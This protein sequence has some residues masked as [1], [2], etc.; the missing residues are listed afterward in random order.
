MAPKNNERFAQIVG[1][2]FAALG[3]TQLEFKERG[4]PSDTT[5]RKILDG[6]PVGISTRTLAGLDRAFGWT[7]GSAARTLAGGTPAPMSKDAGLFLSKIR[8]PRNSGMVNEAID[9]GDQDLVAAIEEVLETGQASPAALAQFERL[10]DDAN[11]RNFPQTYA[12]L[13]REGQLKVAAYGHQVQREE[14]EQR[15]AARNAAGSDGEGTELLNNAK[16]GASLLDALPIAPE[17]SRN[18]VS[19]AKHGGDVADSQ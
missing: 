9:N 19:D 1:E 18:A 10:R 3:V 5:L 12:S 11:I 8:H 16:K 15:L 4:G 14:F 13:S 17:S 7:P 2:A 6:E